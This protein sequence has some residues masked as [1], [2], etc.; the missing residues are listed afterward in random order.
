M[1]DD[2]LRDHPPGPGLRHLPCDMVVWDATICF[3]PEVF[4][5]DQFKV[6]IPLSWSPFLTVLAETCT[7]GQIKIKTSQESEGCL[8]NCF[9]FPSTVYSFV[10]QQVKLIPNHHCLLMGWVHIPEGWLTWSVHCEEYVLCLYFVWAM[11][12]ETNVGM[13]IL[14]LYHFKSYLVWFYRLQIK[15]LGWSII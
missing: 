15:G 3:V 10:Q 6:L 13:S 9:S 4:D 14:F 2:L 8:A 12:R 7:V 5:W 1:M 11:K